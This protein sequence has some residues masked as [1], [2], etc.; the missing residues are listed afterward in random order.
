[1]QNWEMWVKT[2]LS[3]LGH[4]PVEDGLERRLAE[5]ALL[6]ILLV[7]FAFESG[8]HSLRAIVVGVAARLVYCVD[9]VATGHEDLV[10][11]SVSSAIFRRRAKDI[12]ARMQWSMPVDGLL[13]T[14]AYST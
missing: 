13:Q 9:G 14:L 7:L 8:T 5:T 3:R 1:M 2:Y 12:P 11:V 4:D 6:A 10:F